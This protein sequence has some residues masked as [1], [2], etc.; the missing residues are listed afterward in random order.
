MN[1]MWRSYFQFSVCF[2][3]SLVS[4]FYFTLQGWH[5]YGVHFLGFFGHRFVDLEMGFLEF[6]GLLFLFF[7]SLC[8]FLV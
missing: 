6:N 4:A 8:I 7:A 1:S 3:S 2:P 5:T